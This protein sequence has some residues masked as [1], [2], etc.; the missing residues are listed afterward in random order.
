MLEHSQV[1]KFLD[2]VAEASRKYGVEIAGCGCCGSPYLLPLEGTHG[3]Y[4]INKKEHV[5]EGLDWKLEE[6]VDE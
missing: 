6:V 5:S 2:E 1:V 4:R 3:A